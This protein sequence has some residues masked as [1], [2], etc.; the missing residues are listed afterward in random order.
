MCVRTKITSS[1]VTQLAGICGRDPGSLTLDSSIDE[2]KL[3]SLALPNVLMAFEE[4]FSIELRED[5][6]ISLLT[7]RQIKDY[8]EVLD[9]AV[10]RGARGN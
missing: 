9:A 2:L 4:E 7:A 5:E 1:V 10:H 8:V 3:D 6:V